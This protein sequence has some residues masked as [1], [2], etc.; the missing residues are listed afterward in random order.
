M[1]EHLWIDGRLIPSAGDRHPA[2]DLCLQP[3]FIG[4]EV[5]GVEPVDDVSHQGAH[6]IIVD[7]R[8]VGPRDALAVGI[9]LNAA[10][11]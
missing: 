3:G 8:D 11:N 5:E 7:A 9:L 1:R 4:A 2:S 6:L 10:E